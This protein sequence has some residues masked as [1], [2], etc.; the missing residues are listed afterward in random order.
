M[1]EWQREKTDGEQK[2][3]V[4]DHS[5]FA[6]P[7]DN[8]ANRPTLHRRSNNPAKRDE[9]AAHLHVL[10]CLR[11][12]VEVFADQQSQRRLERSET[13]GRQEEHTSELQSL[14]YLVCRLL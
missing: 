11:I 7:F 6:A 12:Q 4:G 10:V 8:P 3:A 2:H 14:A 1:D 13:K 5:R 9:V